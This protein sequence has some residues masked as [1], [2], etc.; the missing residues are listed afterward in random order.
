[1][2]RNATSLQAALLPA[3]DARQ[4]AG[5]AVFKRTGGENVILPDYDSGEG[6]YLDILDLINGRGSRPGYDLQ[7]DADTEW[8]AIGGDGGELIIELLPSDLIRITNDDA[9]EDIIVTAPARYGF[10]GIYEVEAGQSITAPSD[11]MRGNVGTE[12]YIT[13]ER[14]GETMVIPSAPGIVQ[15]I[16]TLLRKRGTVGGLD[17]TVQ[18]DCLER[19]DELAVGVDGIRWSID[20]T[21]RIVITA[22]DGTGAIQWLNTAFRDRLGFSGSEPVEDIGA[23]ATACERQVASR[24]VVLVPSRPLRRFLPRSEYVGDALRLTDGSYSTATTGSYPGWII[25][26][27]ID[28]PLDVGD[29]LH[30][31]WIDLMTVHAPIGH[32][33]TLYLDW[34]DSRRARLPGDHT[35]TYTTTYTAERYG[36]MPYAGRLLCRVHPDSGDVIEIEQEGR[37]WRRYPYR[38]VLSQ[39]ES[40][41]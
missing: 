10:N 17:D 23:G 12:D 40:G 19:M 41:V 39:R 14:D 25:E 30:R 13:I 26:G 22:P 4:W 27:W 3:F 33:L 37:Y 9:V 29:D 18:A 15:D 6:I 24:P 7:T 1:M 16:P 32:P 5:T 35:G 11:W 31:M 34:G 20:S 2:P 28:G 8:Q 36:Y 21:G 38:L